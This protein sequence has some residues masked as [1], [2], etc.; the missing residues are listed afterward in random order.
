[1]TTHLLYHA[2][3]LVTMDA[4]RRELT[5]GALVIRDHEIIAV[6]TTTELLPEWEPRADH[7]HNMKGMVV[8]PGLVNTHHHLYQ[9]LTRALPAAQDAKLFDWLVAHY[10]IWANLTGEMVYISALTGLMELLLSGCTTAAD[11]LYL[12][13]NDCT[14]D[15]EIR[16]AQELGIRFHPTRGSMS[17]GR[18]AGGLPPDS[19]V[20]SES[21]ILKETQRAIEQWHQ[22]DRF[23]MI[24]VGVAPCSPFSVTPDLMR[25]SAAL[26]RAYNVG[27]HTH[28]AE[29]LDEEAFC[30]EKFGLRPADY[31]ESLGW[32]GKDVWWAH[33]VHVNHADI[34]QMGQTGTGMSHCPSSNMRLASGIAP[35]RAMCDN[36]VKV[37]LGVDGSASNDCCHLLNEARQAML[38]QR[39]MG[40]PNAMSARESLEIATLGGAAV[41]GRDDIGAIAPGMAADVIGFRVDT[42]DHAGATPHDPVAAL[43]FCYPRKADFV[44][45]NGRQVVSNG[46]LI[47]WDSGRVVARHNELALNLVQGV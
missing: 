47:G 2:T 16:A 7:L 31:A 25:K 46:E 33:A 36:G 27:L 5:D 29:T 26:A 10:P 28:L 23:G 1:M 34:V 44:M 21:A 9:T 19:V 22:P 42:L 8:L 37:S 14:I 41:L 38:L 6:G 12:Y 43:L 30:L 11:H 18:S 17:L 24:R 4:D 40:Q 32:T 45:V 20:E 3:R 15:D 35:I 39:V 13:P